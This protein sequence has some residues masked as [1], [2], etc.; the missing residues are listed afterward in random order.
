MPYLIDGSNLIGYIP[1]LELSDPKSKHRLAAQLSIFQATKKTKI[2]L[3]FDGP[4]DPDLFGKNFQRKEF[5]ILWPD[6]EE[7]ADTLIKQRI[8]KQT[9][10]RHFYVVSSDREIKTFAR[11]NRATVLDCEEF[12]KLLK[13]AL[14]EYKESQ[15]INK[16]DITLSPLEVDHWLEIFGASDE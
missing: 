4:P 16:E 6:L 2:I 13:T 11:V 3:V 1:T 10:L 9:D 7:S 8:K 12:H 15:A 5:A 14:K